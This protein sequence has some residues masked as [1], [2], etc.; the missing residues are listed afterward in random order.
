[1]HVGS[2]R[3]ETRH[4]LY[5]LLH[6]LIQMDKEKINELLLECQLDRFKFV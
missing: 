4:N 2:Y 1:M 3:Q 5:K 6:R